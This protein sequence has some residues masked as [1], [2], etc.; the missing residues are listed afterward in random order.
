MGDIR[1][2]FSIR[3]SFYID[4][5]GMQLLDTDIYG[6]AQVLI[7]SDWT[8]YI[9]CLGVN[10]LVGGYGDVVDFQNDYKIKTFNGSLNKTFYILFQI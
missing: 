2:Y 8:A 3:S 4:S 6:L 7:I 10:S 9:I 1:F 5:G